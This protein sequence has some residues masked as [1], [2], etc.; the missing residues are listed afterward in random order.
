MDRKEAVALMA[1]YQERDELRRIVRD[2][3]ANRRLKSYREAKARLK[4]LTEEL[5]DAIVPVSPDR[6]LELVGWDLEHAREE[7]DK[8]K[9]AWIKQALESPKWAVDSAGRVIKAEEKWRW[10]YPATEKYL[11]IKRGDEV[12]PEQVRELI[13][14]RGMI[15]DDLRREQFSYTPRATTCPYGR[16]ID[17]TV[18][19][20]R[21][22]TL[23]WAR[24]WQYVL[25]G[26]EVWELAHSEEAG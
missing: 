7:F 3:D 24:D 21:T 10:L 17:A 23:R 14:M 22:E 25:D 20:C 6:A 16:A 15:E 9:A 8:A 11:E 5:D 19:E 26:L 18:A 2:P 12:A 13:A 4:A 1:K